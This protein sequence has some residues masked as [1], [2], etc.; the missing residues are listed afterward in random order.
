MAKASSK[1]TKTRAAA[2]K[3]SASAPQPAAAAKPAAPPTASAAA[4]AA[5]PAPQPL[6]PS[7]PPT[8][9]V[10]KDERH[11]M[12]AEAAYYISVRRGPSSDPTK[13]WLEAERQIDAQLLRDGRL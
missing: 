13:N 8:T 6:T 5:A 10:T 9:K 11:R 4:P 3:A 12:I 1:S 2:K 7:A